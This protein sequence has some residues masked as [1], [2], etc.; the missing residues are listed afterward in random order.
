VITSLT[1][2]SPARRFWTVVLLAV[3]LGLVAAAQRD[4][5]LRPVDQVRGSR[6]VW[7]IV[8]TNA[9]GAVAY[10]GFGRRT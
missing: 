6:L 7:R 8:C 2:L 1:D 5:Q 4:L 3:S 10:F 9:L